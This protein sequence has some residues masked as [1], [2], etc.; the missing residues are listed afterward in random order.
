M[1]QLLINSV[2]RQVK[3]LVP[4][5]V[6]YEDLALEIL[7]TSWLNKIEVPSLEFIRQRCFNAI[8]NAKLE[9]VKIQHEPKTMIEPD[10]Q[11]EI[12][13]RDEV[14]MLVSILSPTEKKLI[15]YRF[16]QELTLEEISKQTKIPLNLCRDTIQLALHKMRSIA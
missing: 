11:P 15:W 10:I 8:R 3:H 6:D 1:D 7:F 5:Q 12:E 2:T 14:Q 16:Y 4:P 9:H 13:T